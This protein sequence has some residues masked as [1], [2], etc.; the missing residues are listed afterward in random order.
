MTSRRGAPRKL[1][2]A[3]V[4]DILRWH[5]QGCDFLRAHGTLL[6]LAQRLRV[7]VSTLHSVVAGRHRPRCASRGGRPPALSP[8][9]CQD[10]WA[11]RSAD[12]QHRKTHG[13]VADLACRLGV[14]PRTIFACIAR[15]GRVPMNPPT[16]TTVP[17]PRAP[18]A[19]VSRIRATPAMRARERDDA[20]RNALLR[21]WRVPA[22][23]T[24]QLLKPKDVP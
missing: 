3:E 13:T 22:A 6:Q 5:A 17:A 21:A 2:S 23:N 10:V 4:C 24:P 20:L 8:S 15:A 9:Q 18:A 14:S 12:Q 7:S 1:T 11:W 16:A 19:P